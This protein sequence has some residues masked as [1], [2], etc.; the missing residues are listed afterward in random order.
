M[1]KLAHSGISSKVMMELAEHK[2]LSTTQRYIEMND[3]MKRA[4]VEAV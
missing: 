4:A 2:H 3:G 1:T